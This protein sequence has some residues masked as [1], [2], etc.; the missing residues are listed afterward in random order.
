MAICT[1]IRR[2]LAVSLEPHV[3]PLCSFPPTPA[4]PADAALSDLMRLFWNSLSAAN[5]TRELK[6][7]A[8][9]ELGRR[10]DN[11][12]GD[13]QRPTVWETV[14][15]TSGNLDRQTP[16]PR[17]RPSTPSSAASTRRPDR[18]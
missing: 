3:A 5:S 17:S 11:D 13:G 14:A 8:G 1:H 4:A 16:T 15:L 9:V 2:T 7:G 12:R 18:G 6:L 10:H